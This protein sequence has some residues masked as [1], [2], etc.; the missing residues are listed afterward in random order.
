[1]KWQNDE[2]SLKM[3]FF[4][5]LPTTTLLG[6]SKPCYLTKTNKQINELIVYPQINTSSDISRQENANRPIITGN[7]CE[8]EPEL[9]GLSMI[10]WPTQ[11]PSAGNVQDQGPASS[12]S[13]LTGDV[14]EL[15]IDDAAKVVTSGQIQG[16]IYLTDTYLNTAS[17]ITI[18]ISDDLTNQLTTQRTRV[19]WF[20]FKLE[21][22][23]VHIPLEGIQ[24]P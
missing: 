18:P 4:R 16:K 6:V 8:S 2:M 7:M 20:A 3:T 17:F 23:S 10:S 13:S 9:E 14:Y 5:A 11:V 24:M 1:M 15:T 19:M 21:C 12:P 22:F